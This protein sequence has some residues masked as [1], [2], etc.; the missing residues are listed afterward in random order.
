M[1]VSGAYGFDRLGNLQT[2]FICVVTFLVMYGV[3]LEQCGPV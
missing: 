1:H 2:H 3:S